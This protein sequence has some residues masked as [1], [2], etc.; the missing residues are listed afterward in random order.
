MKKILTIIFLIVGIASF[1][2]NDVQVSSLSANKLFYNPAATGYSDYFNAA[3]TYRAQWNPSSGIAGSQRPHAVILN[4]SQYLWNMRSGFGLTVY[5]FR[6]S[7]EN[8]FM[9]KGSY[10]YHI[11]MGD[12]EYLSLGVSAGLMS[13]S[14][15]DAVTPSGNDV[16]YTNLISDLGL[17]L[18][19]HTGDI[20]VGLSC[21][22]IPLVLGNDVAK[23]NP[24]FYFYTTYVYKIDND[25][26]LLPHIVLRNSVFITNVAIGTRVAYLNQFLLGLDYRMDAWSINVGWRFGNMAVG[27]SYD[28]NN[29]AL[30]SRGVGGSHE[31]TMSYNGILFP[32]KDAVEKLKDRKDF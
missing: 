4:M 21:A 12:E 11:Q 15:N 13:H 26:K 9:I 23:V 30:Q 20:I 25:W 10:A 6:H 29:G 22:H 5:D 19:Y 7:I 14:V 18:E 2:Q 28:I 24:H 17:G 31:I 32:I 8:Q 27:Y 3:L 1:A 16:D